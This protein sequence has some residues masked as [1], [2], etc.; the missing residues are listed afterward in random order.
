M[1]KTSETKF[2]LLGRKTKWVSGVTFSE[3]IN[4]ENTVRFTATIR[5]WQ[6]W[7][8]WQGNGRYTPLGLIIE[9]AREIRDRIDSGDES[10]FE[11]SNK[12]ALVSREA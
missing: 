6:G 1:T 11:L 9:K 4:D 8:L 3:Y 10:V 5:G 7:F 2:R 12:T